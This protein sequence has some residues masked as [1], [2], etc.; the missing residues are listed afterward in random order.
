MESNIK[1]IKVFESESE[2]S[3]QE[4]NMC[5]VTVDETM[6]T[7]AKLKNQL[8]AFAHKCPHA[9]GIMAEGYIDALGNA[10]CPVHKYRFSIKTGRNVTGED[11]LKIYLIESSESGVYIGFKEKNFNFI[12]EN[13]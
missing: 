2:I 4:N 9:G 5:I 3:W 8:F 10:V 13:K 7:I 12:K 1:W 11:Y 6:L